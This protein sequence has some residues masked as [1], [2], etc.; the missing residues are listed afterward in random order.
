VASGGTVRV[1]A[2]ARQP[3]PSGT[4]HKNAPARIQG[5]RAARV[6]DPVC[7]SDECILLSYPIICVA[8]LINFFL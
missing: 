1:C 4:K 2:T 3:R 5:P 8:N 6:P 7:V